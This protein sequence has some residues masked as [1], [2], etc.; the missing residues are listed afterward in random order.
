MWAVSIRRTE[1]R[2]SIPGLLDELELSTE[3]MFLG[4]NTIQ[5]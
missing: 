4:L 5:V 1:R 3:V 2:V